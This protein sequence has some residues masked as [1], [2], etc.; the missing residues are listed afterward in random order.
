MNIHH[1][2]SH[3]DGVKGIFGCGLAYI[4]QQLEVYHH[5]RVF[6]H[7][8]ENQGK[9][10]AQANILK[11]ID[12]ATVDFIMTVDSDTLLDAQGKTQTRYCAQTE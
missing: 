3:K 2:T 10:H 7:R 12:P 9:R 5:P 4:L 1:K 8:Q 6:C 11:K